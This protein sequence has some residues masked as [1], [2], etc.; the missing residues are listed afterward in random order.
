MIS[1]YRKTFYKE[2]KFDEL[3]QDGEKEKSMARDMRDRLVLFSRKKRLQVEN[4][5]DADSCL[6]NLQLGTLSR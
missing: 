6:S 1:I 5:E 4:S 2:Q 3:G